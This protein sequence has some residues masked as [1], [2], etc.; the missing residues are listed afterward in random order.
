LRLSAY[1]CKLNEILTLVCEWD[2]AALE[3][4]C[5]GKVVELLML[6]SCLYDTFRED[7]SFKLATFQSKSGRERV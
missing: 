7:E 3:S 2:Q 4:Y 1:L 5:I 6:F